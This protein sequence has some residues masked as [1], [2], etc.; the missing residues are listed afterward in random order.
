M[1]CGPATRRALHSHSPGR[2]LHE[3]V[4]ELAEDAR[5]RHEDQD[6]EEEGAE[7]VGEEP[8]VGVLGG[9]RLEPDEDA[10]EHDA[11]VL[12]RVADRVDEGRPL[13][14]RLA[15]PR[16]A[17]AGLYRRLRGAPPGRGPLQARFHQRHA[18][19]LDVGVARGL[20]LAPAGRPGG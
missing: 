11:H 17:R 12:H 2:A 8:Q 5:G 7:G 3:D 4:A 10:G 16:L 6:G 18:V 9:A 13:V 14:H 19:R 1:A 20:A 15:L